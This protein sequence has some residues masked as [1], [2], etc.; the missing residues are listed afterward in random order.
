M[1]PLSMRGRSE[2]T[3]ERSGDRE[4]LVSVSGLD[5]SLSFAARCWGSGRKFSSLGVNDLLALESS[6]P[7]W[8]VSLPERYR[9]FTLVKKSP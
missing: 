4:G 9:G 1:T 2:A 7:G 6:V 3:P 5:R 8:C